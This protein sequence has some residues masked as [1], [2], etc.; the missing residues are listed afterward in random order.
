[1][2]KADD[3]RAE[4][5]RG[6]T[7]G[8]P[9]PG[10]GAQR[11][12]RHGARGD[13][14]PAPARHAGRP[15]RARTG[16]QPAPGAR[17]A[18]YSLVS[19]RR[20]PSAGTRGRSC[21]TL[22]ISPERRAPVHPGVDEPPT[23]THGKRDR[24]PAIVVISR[25]EERYKGHDVL[26]RALP[27]V[28]SRVPGAHLHVIGDGTLRGHLEALAART[29]CG[30]RGDVPRAGCPIEE[31]DEIM[32]RSSVFAMLSRVDALG[33]GEGFGIVYV[34]AGRLGLPV[35]AGRVAGALDAVVDGETGI[36][37][38][39]EDH[40]GAADAISSLLA[41]PRLAQRL[42]DRRARAC[43]GSLV[44]ACRRRRRGRARPGDRAMRVL[45]VNHTARVS[46]AER[47]LLELMEGVRA[48]RR[49]PSCLS[50]G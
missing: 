10:C 35:V 20:S 37:V 7:R 48:P 23:T 8:A 33:S 21:S 47:S 27:L 9:A 24:E 19:T 18:E 38:D 4:C 28:R 31:R 6:G 22:G 41:D 2:R 39:P 16:G 12:H 29:R 5:R 11:A 50:G 26:L 42:G 46:G 30:R 45:Y 32:R 25:L 40:V 1:M 15:V 34:E 36:L 3:R 13:R 17:P 49:R 14:R 44:A 43:T